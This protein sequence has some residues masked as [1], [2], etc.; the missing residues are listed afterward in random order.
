VVFQTAFRSPLLALRSYFEGTERNILP[1]KVLLRKTALRSPLS[2]PALR[3][4]LLALILRE[5]SGGNRAK[6]I[7]LQEVLLRKTALR[8]LLFVLASRSP[9]FASRSYFE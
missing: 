7:L 2:L 4:S 8:F 3:S 9:L 1:Q 5:Q 6:N